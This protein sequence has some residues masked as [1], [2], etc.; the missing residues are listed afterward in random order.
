MSKYYH[1][2]DLL[3]VLRDL[4]LPELAHMGTTGNI[5]LNALVAMSMNQMTTMRGTAAETFS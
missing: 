3:L 5:K 1:F 4:L 2:E